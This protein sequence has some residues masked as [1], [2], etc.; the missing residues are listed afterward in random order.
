MFFISDLFQLT[1]TIFN[2]FSQKIK[3]FNE[4]TCKYPRYDNVIH[5]EFG[6]QWHCIGI[7]KHTESS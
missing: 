6:M 7:R 3:T 1:T 4:T 5:L 2:S